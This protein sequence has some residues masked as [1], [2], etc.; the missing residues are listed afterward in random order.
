MAATTTSPPTVSTG[1]TTLP[2][3][4]ISPR[5]S[6]NEP[7]G[8]V[9]ALGL[10]AERSLARGKQT[11]GLLPGALPFVDFANTGADR[12][13]DD[14]WAWTA[15]WNWIGRNRGT[16]P[17]REAAGYDWSLNF[18]SVP[19]NASSTIPQ[20]AVKLFSRG[21]LDYLAIN[22]S[23]AF[24]EGRATSTTVWVTKAGRVV[25]MG[26]VSET[27]ARCDWTDRTAN[28]GGGRESNPPDEDRSSR[29][30]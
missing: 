5:T 12:F 30:F 6:V 7:V 13:S 3:T 10:A 15:G 1:A 9:S 4:T 11:T 26:T 21:E 19:A 20:M 28:G 18:S 23:C 14:S 25:A 2:S 16:L 29:P 17:T 22:S 27:V 8:P 24:G